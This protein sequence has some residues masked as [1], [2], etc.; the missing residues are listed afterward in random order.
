MNLRPPMQLLLYI[1]IH[2]TGYSMSVTNQSGGIYIK[3]CIL[4]KTDQRNG[5]CDCV[6]MAP[7]AMCSNHIV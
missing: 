5:S 2:S 7:V 3:R 1:Y 6:V 4:H